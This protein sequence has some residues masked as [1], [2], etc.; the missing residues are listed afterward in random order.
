MKGHNL[1]SKPCTFAGKGR[2]FGY[3]PVE[4]ICG[5]VPANW[6]KFAGGCPQIDEICGG[7]TRKL[8]VI[9]GGV[10]ANWENLRGYLHI[11]GNFAGGYP[12]IGS[13]FAG[14]YPQWASPPNYVVIHQIC[15]PYHVDRKLERNEIVYLDVMRVFRPRPLLTVNLDPD[16]V[17]RIGPVDNVTRFVHRR[18]WRAACVSVLPRIDTTYTASGRLLSV[19]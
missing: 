15:D 17:L 5:G 12:Q 7:G 4:V 14:G 2:H 19:A 8:V 13:K 9:C 16:T 3:S 11:K 1:A 10:P 6:E 18:T